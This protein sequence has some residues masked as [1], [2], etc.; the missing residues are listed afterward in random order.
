M[1][2][3]HGDQAAETAELVLHM[4]LPLHVAAFGVACDGDV[5]HLLLLL[6][7]LNAIAVAQVTAITADSL[8]ALVAATCDVLV[9]LHVLL[10][11]FMQLQ[12][13]LLLHALL[14]RF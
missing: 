8:G 1:V 7:L 13:Y 14:L 5:R 2:D 4:L 9:L 12:G 11:L 3:N 10:L 6:L